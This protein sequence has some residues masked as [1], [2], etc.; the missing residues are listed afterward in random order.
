MRI[1][2]N[3]LAPVI[4]DGFIAVCCRAQ[5]KVC[6]SAKLNLLWHDERLGE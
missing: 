3:T 1:A 2:K 4:T 6:Q 5:M